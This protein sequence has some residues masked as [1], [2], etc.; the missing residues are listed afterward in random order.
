M[1][2]KLREVVLPYNDKGYYQLS[3]RDHKTERYKKIGYVYGRPYTIRKYYGNLYKDLR[4]DKINVINISNKPSF[5]DIYDLW[6][7]I[8]ENS[9]SEV[10]GFAKGYHSSV[11]TFFKSMRA[12]EKIRLINIEYLSI[13]KQSVLNKAKVEDRI[14]EFR[15]AIT[16][17]E[18]DIK[19]AE[20]SFLIPKECKDT[21]FYSD[22][23]ETLYECYNCGRML[24]D[25]SDHV[26][27]GC[28]SSIYTCKKRR[29]G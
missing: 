23:Q 8:D 20:K 11:L 27:R 2:G 4:L 3:Y 12:S 19:K 22:G 25:T 26:D 16:R 9:P 10:I 14:K 17:L 24:K 21:P 29:L 5:T 15:E 6:C 18:L 13:D 7:I 28:Q 1:S